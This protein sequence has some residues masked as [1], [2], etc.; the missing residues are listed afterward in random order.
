MRL[1]YLLLFVLAFGFLAC[2]EGK[3]SKGSS[4]TDD[5]TI[6]KEELETDSALIK[7]IEEKVKEA[8]AYQTAP[9]EQRHWILSQ[10]I[11]DGKAMNVSNDVEID[12]S[13]AKGRIQGNSGCNNYFASFKVDTLASSMTVMGLG[14]TKKACQGA[15]AS[16]ERRFQA[17][18]K[19]AGSYKLN[20]GNLELSGEKGS[21]I[22]GLATK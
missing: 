5:Y 4:D 14:A 1:T 16:Q 21:L 6:S 15:A 19:S 18:L 17:I 20:E 13:F 8:Q 22:F 10:F 9:F 3:K 11:I 2:G 12:A 7:Q